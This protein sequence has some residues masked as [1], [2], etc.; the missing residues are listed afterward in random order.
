MIAK[1]GITKRDLFFDKT[2]IIFITQPN[3]DNANDNDNDNDKTKAKHA[4]R[5]LALIT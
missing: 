5:P 1:S 4:S 3:N 2:S